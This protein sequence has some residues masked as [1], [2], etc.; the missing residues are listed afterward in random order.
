M[1]LPA[2]ITLSIKT[3]KKYPDHKETLD[4]IRLSQKLARSKKPP[5]K[6]IEEIGQGWV[7]EEA[8]AISV[9]CSLKFPDN[10]VKSV[11]AAVNHSGDSDSTG[12]ITGAIMGTM[13]GIE[14]IPDR[15]VK[16]IEDSDMIHRLAGALFNS[17]EKSQL[18]DRFLYNKLRWW[19]CSAR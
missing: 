5:E 19:F 17:F 11:L 12:A 18:I 16:D 13:L 10:W 1:K 15:W 2:S 8:L 6:A 7:G 4:N 9:Y 3:L 14:A